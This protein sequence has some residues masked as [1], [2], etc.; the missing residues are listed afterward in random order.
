MNENTRDK[1]LRKKED[2]VIQSLEELSTAS[3]KL[4][5]LKDDL[6][7]LI[8]YSKETKLKNNN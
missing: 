8:T 3:K 4:E 6:K 5:A 1:E 7:S 2:A